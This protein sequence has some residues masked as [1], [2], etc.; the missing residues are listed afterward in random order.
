MNGR[1]QLVL[2]TAALLLPGQALA[3]DQTSVFLTVRLTDG[4]LEAEILVAERDLD[5]HFWA[6]AAA[7][8]LRD[9][10]TAVQRELLARTH[11][12]ADQR[13]V[14]LEPLARVQPRPGRRLAFRFHAALPRPPSHVTVET[15]FAQRLGPGHVV[16]VKIVDGTRVRQTVLVAEAPRQEFRLRDAPTL[17][18]RLVRFARLGIEHIFLGYDHILFLIALII[19]GDRF[20]RLVQ[21][22]TAFT[23]AHS[24]TLALAGLELVSLPPRLVEAL[25]ALT[26]VYV[27][28]ENLILKDVRHRIA[29]TF[30]FGLIHG[31]GFANILGDLGLPREALVGSLLAFNI[32]V[33]IGQFV[34]LLMVF[35]AVV[36]LLRQPYRRQ[37]TGLVSAAILVCGLTWLLERTTSWEL[38]PW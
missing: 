9:D 33:E 19:S 11:L 10:T 31:F 32:G 16:L 35:P 23:L 38:V 1:W 36:L 3:H 18:S 21:I 24:V 17:P 22:A 20:L 34:I 4:G 8:T 26:I 7:Q 28:A 6:G 37:V 2:A 5:E 12:F 15:A 29:L 30:G 13:R 14:A 27:A 25:I